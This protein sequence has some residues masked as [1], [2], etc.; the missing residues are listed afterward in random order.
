M[1]KLC[2]HGW[3][4]QQAARICHRTR[5]LHAI[6]AE[7]SAPART[8]DK[9]TYSPWVDGRPFI[10]LRRKCVETIVA[11]GGKSDVCV[12]ATVF[13]AIDLGFHVIV[14]SDTVC[15][16]AD[17]THDAAAELLGERFSVKL[18][19]LKT[20]EFLATAGSARTFPR[21]A[22]YHRPIGLHP[23]CTNRMTKLQPSVSILPFFQ[24]L[25]NQRRKAGQDWHQSSPRARVHSF[26]AVANPAKPVCRD[27][28]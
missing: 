7:A 6:L 28:F 12:L 26:H 16:C 2:G 1:F 4:V 23:R 20:D 3:F 8:F 14:F 18:D 27:T 9:M 19:L 24:L 17:K 10:H 22:A 11:T 15:S 13:G 21:G 5:G 25:V